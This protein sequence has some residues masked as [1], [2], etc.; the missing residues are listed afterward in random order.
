[1]TG[2]G[3][4]GTKDDDATNRHFGNAYVGTSGDATIQ[5]VGF[6]DATDTVFFQVRYGS[7]PLEFSKGIDVVEV[8]K[9]DSLPNVIDT[10]AKAVQAGELDQQLATAAQERK[11]NFR[12]K[13]AGKVT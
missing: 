1:M 13:A 5:P 3:R 12:K 4:L 7:K 10:L 9:L 8:G 6:Q 11:K 2:Q